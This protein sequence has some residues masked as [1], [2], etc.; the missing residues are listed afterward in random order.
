[1]HAEGERADSQSRTRGGADD[2]NSSGLFWYHA[3]VDA[4]HS[5]ARVS[6]LARRSWDCSG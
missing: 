3:G 4:K 6:S 1:M 5:S 2:Y